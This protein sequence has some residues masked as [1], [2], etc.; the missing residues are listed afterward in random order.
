MCIRDSNY[1][2]RH[3]S[4]GGG[5]TTATG[6]LQDVVRN[7]YEGGLYRLVYSSDLLGQPGNLSVL[8]TV[9]QDVKNRQAYWVAAG[10]DI[11][12]WWHQ[13]RNVE[14]FVEERSRTRLVIRLT[15]RNDADVRDVGLSVSL[16]Q[17]VTGVQVKSEVVRPLERLALQTNEAD[18][19]RLSL[20][21][22]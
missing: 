14:A 18:H 19:P 15:N 3:D 7:E 8:R 22:I 10:D 1:T 17:S 11:A 12:T 5:G 13:R 6:Y 20:I 2:A 16:G 4:L 9:A 21:H